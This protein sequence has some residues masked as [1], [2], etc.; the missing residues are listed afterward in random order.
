LEHVE[1]SNPDLLILDVEMPQVSG[2]ELCQ[3][4][5]N[6]PRWSELPV[7][8]LSAHMDALTVNRVFTAGADDYVSKP[9]LGPE[10]IARVLNRL[11]RTHI[12]HRVAETDVLTGVAN[13]RK[14][15][16]ELPRLLHLAA[17]EAKPL[18]L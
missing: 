2:I 10:L 3:V 17:R 1:Q 5:R 12:L 18:C 4:V 13:R 9:I 7:L 11:E 14:F 16:Q 15:I 6:D 8:F